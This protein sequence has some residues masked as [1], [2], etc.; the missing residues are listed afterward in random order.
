MRVFEILQKEN[1]CASVVR[2]VV[3][4]PLIAAKAQ[5]GQFVILRVSED[6]ERIPLT[7]A[8]YDRVD[9]AVTIIFQTVGGPCDL[10]TP[11]RAGNFKLTTEFLNERLVAVRIFTAKLMVSVCGKDP[12][13][14]SFAKMQE[15]P[16][17]RHAVR[18]AGNRQQDGMVRPPR[19]RIHRKETFLKRFLNS[20]YGPGSLWGRV[21]LQGFSTSFRFQ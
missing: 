1:L 6:G 12:Q 13:A 21:L 15:K 14:E 3:R 20:R 16:Q 5:A 18:T 10:Q 4:A 9:G 2:M 8:D 17:E 11:D 7:V 19:K